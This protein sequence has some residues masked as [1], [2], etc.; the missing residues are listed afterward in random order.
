MEPFLIK[1]Y[2]TAGITFA[3]AICATTINRFRNVPAGCFALAG[4]TM[5]WVI[6]VMAYR[7][8]NYTAVLLGLASI[9]SLFLF[10]LFFYS[11]EE[12]G[13]MRN[14][15]IGVTIVGMCA[16]ITFGVFFGY[17]LLLGGL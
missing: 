7:W 2:T 11:Y 9:V 16:G 10:A 3:T 17:P 14:I 1:I 5:P 8:L 13:A 15:A 6:I 12:P 4:G